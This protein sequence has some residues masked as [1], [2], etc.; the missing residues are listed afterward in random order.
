M[1]LYA[2]SEHVESSFAR[3]AAARASSLWWRSA[4]VVHRWKWVRGAEE[5]INEDT[6]GSCAF[7][8]GQSLAW[9]R[10]MSMWGQQ[11]RTFTLP[12]RGRGRLGMSPENP[13]VSLSVLDCRGGENP[14]I[15]MIMVWALFLTTSELHGSFSFRPQPGD[16]VSSLCSTAGWFDRPSIRLIE[17]WLWWFRGCW[18]EGAAVG[19]IP[20]EQRQN[21]GGQLCLWTVTS[22]VVVVA[23]HG[24]ELVLQEWW[25]RWVSQSS[26]LPEWGKLL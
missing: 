14:S 6:E 21:S 16:K 1:G 12:L 8:Q 4:A 3:L 13:R 19:W 24:A 26:V 23:V 11:G 7:G 22:A 15:C 25:R 9:M 18:L 2:I 10:I 17:P 20:S 5:I